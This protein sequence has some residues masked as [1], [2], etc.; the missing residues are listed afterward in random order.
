MRTQLLAALAFALVATLPLESA[1]PK[2]I[3]LIA[4]VPS[5]GPGEHEHNAGT[6]LLEKQL[7]QVPGVLPV[8]HLNGWPKDESIFEGAAAILIYS[9][10]GG[11]HPAVQGDRLQKL[12]RLMDKGVGLACIHYAVEVPK[13][14]AGEEFLRW[15]GGY[16]ETH[17]SVNPHWTPD[18]KTIPEHPVTRGVKP[19]TLRDEWY[20]HMRFQ[21]GMKGVTPLLSDV[22]PPDTLQRPDG[23]HSGNPH[24]R[25]AVAAGEPQH[26]AWAYE[27]PGGGRGFGFTGAHFHRNWAQDDFRKIVLNALLWVAHVEVPKNGVESTVT[28]EDLKENLDPKGR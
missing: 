18:F 3:V 22:P 11:G 25:A 6:L 14:Q 24:V 7:K 28:P 15:V 9:D 20:Y 4:G 8:V 27:R 10:G 12:G 5:H 19:F 13:D 21:P 26:V 23:P 2:K 16:F 17:W 1:E